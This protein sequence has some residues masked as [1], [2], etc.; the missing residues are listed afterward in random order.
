MRLRTAFFVVIVVAGVYVCGAY[1][2]AF[3][4]RAEAAKFVTDVLRTIAQPWRVK[5]ILQ[6]GSLALRASAS[7]RMDGVVEV[8]RSALGDYVKGNEHVTCRLFRGIDTFSKKEYTYAS[9]STKAAFQKKQQEM[10]ISLVQQNGEWRI[11]NIVA[12]K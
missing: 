2:R 9:C 3:F 1:V 4:W 5:P 11:D 12:N 8:Y 7:D 6:R 10:T